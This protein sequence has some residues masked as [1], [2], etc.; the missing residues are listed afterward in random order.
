MATL[1]QADLKPLG[2]H[3][4]VV[5]LE[6]ASLLDRVGSTRDYEAAIVAIT[7]TDADPTA[8]LNV[9]QSSG[10]TH[11]WNPRQKTPATPWEAEVD[12][13]M[14]QQMVTPNYAAR[15]RLFDRVQEIVMGN[16]PLVPLVTPH[17]LTGAKRDLGN[18]SGAALDPYALWNVEEIYWRKAG[19]PAGAAR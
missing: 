15:K 3:V 13:L 11:F 7:S 9:W 8:D 16:M 1:I 2:V 14:Q 10:G 19:G 18:V 12:R 5:P 6:F 4:D 17:L